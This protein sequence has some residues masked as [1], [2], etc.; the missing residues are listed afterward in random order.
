MVDQGHYPF[1]H[2]REIDVENG[3][4]PVEIEDH[5]FDPSKLISLF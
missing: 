4:R 5:R 1:S 2:Q 3:Q